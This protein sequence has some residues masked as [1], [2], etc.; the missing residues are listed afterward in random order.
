MQYCPN[1]LLIQQVHLNSWEDISAISKRRWEQE[2]STGK[3][4]VIFVFKCSSFINEISSITAPV[5]L[6]KTLCSALRLL[7]SLVKLAFK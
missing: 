6:L 4:S 2:A 3:N 5:F 1:S 7:A